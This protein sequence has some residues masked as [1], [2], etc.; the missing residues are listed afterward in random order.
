M[1][2]LHHPLLKLSFCAFA[3]ATLCLLVTTSRVSASDTDKPTDEDSVK[4]ISLSEANEPP[5]TDNHNQVNPNQVDVTPAYNYV[6]DVL[7][8]VNNAVSHIN[9]VSSQ[10][11]DSQLDNTLLYNVLAFGMDRFFAE[12]AKEESVSWSDYLKNIKDQIQKELK[13]SENPST[14][15]DGVLD[16]SLNL[17][18]EVDGISARLTQAYVN[19][20]LTNGDVAVE[21]LIGTFLDLRIK[22]LDDHDA[23]WQSL[24]AVHK[25]RSAALFSIVSE[26]GHKR[27][28]EGENTSG[29]HKRA[30]EGENTSGDTILRSAES[31]IPGG[32]SPDDVTGSAAKDDSALDKE[33]TET[34]GSEG[35]EIDAGRCKADVDVST[36]PGG[37]VEE[38]LCVFNEIYPT[39]ITQ[40]RVAINQWLHNCKY[41]NHVGTTHAKNR[42]FWKSTLSLIL[43]RS[44]PVRCDEPVLRFACVSIAKVVFGI[45]RTEEIIPIHSLYPWSWFATGPMEILVH[46]L[47]NEVDFDYEV[48]DAVNSFSDFVPMDKMEV[49]GQTTEWKEWVRGFIDVGSKVGV[50]QQVQSARETALKY[51]S[52]DLSSNQLANA[53]V[54]GIAHVLV[55]FPWKKKHYHKVLENVV[56]ALGRE[57]SIIHSFDGEGSRPVLMRRSDRK[58]GWALPW[59]TPGHKRRN[60][61][62]DV[63]GC[64]DTQLNRFY[65]PNPKAIFVD[66]VTLRGMEFP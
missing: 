25:T 30:E 26:T 16:N 45:Q 36:V 21:V 27:A 60:G 55:R 9:E 20:G 19:A 13:D 7:V 39:M 2:T 64:D 52:L 63:N 3:A 12:W 4:P 35:S 59:S 17:R 46:V 33:A 61:L 28:E 50:T 14:A 66:W 32:E 57:A 48:P 15:K 5:L 40:L 47:R 23:E 51:C 49:D 62:A 18:R 11:G 10:K 6:K 41:E 22:Y 8:M 65:G 1:G 24:P 34:E 53:M 37:V 44:I 56:E 42:D 31:Q 58:Y 43:T 38:V 29:G 54:S